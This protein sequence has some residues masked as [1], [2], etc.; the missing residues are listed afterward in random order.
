MKNP[1][2]ISS[3][4]SFIFR[5]KKETWLFIQIFAYDIELAKINIGKCGINIDDYSYFKSE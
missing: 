2:E 3:M 4:S 5:H 1:R